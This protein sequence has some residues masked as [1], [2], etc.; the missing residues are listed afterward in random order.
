MPVIKHTHKYVRAGGKTG[1]K[2]I[3]ICKHADCSHI[4]HKDLLIFRKSICNRCGIE[5]VL[6]SY[7]ITLKK[8]HCE[9]CTKSKKG[10]EAAKRDMA[11]ELILN[12]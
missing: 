10:D 7:A 9:K 1:K 12:T 5:F 6:D 8:P 2:G 11:I 3:F 4:L